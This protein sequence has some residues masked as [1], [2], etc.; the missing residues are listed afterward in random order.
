MRCY[1]RTCF[2][3]S[4]GWKPRIGRFNFEKPND[5]NVLNNVVEKRSDSVLECLG[6][7][8]GVNGESLGT[9]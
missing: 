5:S 1:N 3:A 7:L 9:V 6:I 4:S 8:S 2:D